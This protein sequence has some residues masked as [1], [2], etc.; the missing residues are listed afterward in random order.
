MALITLQNA[1]LAFGHWPLLDHADFALET[2]E[3]VGLIGRNGTGKSSLLRILAGMDRMDDGALQVQGGIRIAYVP[4]EPEL[5]GASTVFDAASKG[6]DDA[7]KARESYENGGEGQD[8]AALQAR[9]EAL[10]AWNWEARVAETLDRLHLDGQARV[11]DLSGGNRKRVA[12]AG[13]R[14]RKRS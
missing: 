8:L 11:G 14:W 12:L 5:D 6:L 7:I 9:I 4:Q 10:D 2:R 1:Q 3:R 13:W